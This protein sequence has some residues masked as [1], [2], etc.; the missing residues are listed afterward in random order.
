MLEG[1]TKAEEASMKD[2]KRASM[3]PLRASSARIGMA[4]GSSL[5]AAYRLP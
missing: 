1:S 3:P 4:R 5:T 2:E